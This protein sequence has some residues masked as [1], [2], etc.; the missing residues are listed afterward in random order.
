MSKRQIS[1]VIGNREEALNEYYAQTIRAAFPSID[2]TFTVATT[3]PIFIQ[4][5]CDSRTDLAILMPPGNIDPDP[6]RPDT[7]AQGEAV[8]V[9]QAIK[10][11]HP[12]PVIVI[13]AYPVTAEP[14]LAAGAVQF[15]YV[16]AQPG[17]I[18]SAVRACLKL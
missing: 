5:A 17:Q 6:A 3:V 11:T 8:H 12:I 16:P 4:I 13:A 2:F 7:T 1:V 10:T 9:I 15:I 18:E 14:A